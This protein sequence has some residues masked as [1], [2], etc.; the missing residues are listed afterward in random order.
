MANAL[1]IQ[2]S[3]G[4]G[5]GR[6]A[7]WL[8]GCGVELRTLHPYA[9]DELPSRL[10]ADALIVMGGPM[11][12]YDDETSPWLPAT[13]AL[14]AAAVDSGV[15]TLG[16]C[17]GA[18]LLAVA[19]GGR[20]ERGMHGPEI[21]LDEVSSSGTDSVL[22]GGPFP[23]VQW[24]YDTV[25][26]LPP[27]A[28]LLAS[29]AT[30]PV[31]AFRVGDTAWGLQFHLEA[32]PDLVASWAAEEGR[33]VDEIVEPIKAADAVIARIGEELAKRFAAVVKERSA[34]G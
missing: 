12:A 29:S 32:A 23:V 33:D 31:Q 30:Y 14:I 22:L 6:L 10:E 28:T 11:G 15:P 13:K 24:H 21:G 26:V 18:Q 25:T 17:L 7:E 2:H 19:T 4:E 20:V 16:V 5:P 8:P 9:G 1:V 34:P 27:L 3:A